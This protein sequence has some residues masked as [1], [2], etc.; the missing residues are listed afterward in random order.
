MT[1]DYDPSK[2]TK[3][4]CQLRGL[5][6]YIDQHH[7]LDPSLAIRAL[8]RMA[9][10]LELTEETVILNATAKDLAIFLEE[11]DP[12]EPVKKPQKPKLFLV[13]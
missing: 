9:V 8:L 11:P 7:Q 2:D 6:L 12:L 3:L 1:M 13:R 10:F 5:G 4:M